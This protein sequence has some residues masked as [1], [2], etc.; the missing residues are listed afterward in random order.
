MV[1]RA[2]PRTELL[3]RFLLDWTQLDG[4]LRRHVERLTARHGQTPARWKVLTA[5]GC[6]IRTV[7]Q[8]AR[9]MGLTRQAVQ[10]IANQLVDEKLATFDENP[11][12]RASPILSLTPHGQTLDDA[13][14]SDHAAWRDR[15]SRR[16]DASALRSA[17]ETLRRLEHA[18]GHER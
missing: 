14:C 10:R 11:D 7:P 16:L 15:I 1:A 17:I 4:E 8:I 18:V 6:D 13:I 12:H 2:T 5:A 9:R 3:R